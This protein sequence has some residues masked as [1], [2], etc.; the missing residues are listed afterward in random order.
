[1]RRYTHTV[2][3]QSFRIRPHEVMELIDENPEAL[4][5]FALLYEFCRNFEKCVKA[6]G[7]QEHPSLFDPDVRNVGRV[8]KDIGR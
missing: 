2:V 1:M 3:F 5:V 8:Q 6:V 7:L 4:H